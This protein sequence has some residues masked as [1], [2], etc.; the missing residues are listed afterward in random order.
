MSPVTAHVLAIALEERY[1]E[2]RRWRSWY[3][4]TKRAVDTRWVD[5]VAE[6]RVALRELVRIRWTARRAAHGAGYALE[7]NERRLLA[8]DR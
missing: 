6:N 2:L 7:E 5:L 1:H 4:R 8:G 3:R